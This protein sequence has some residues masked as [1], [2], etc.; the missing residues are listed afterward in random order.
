[1][2]SS[3]RNKTTTNGNDVYS[4]SDAWIDG[5][6]GNDWL[7]GAATAQT[8]IGGLGNDTLRGMG[9]DDILWGN[10]TNRAAPASSKGND[11]F[12]FEATRQANGFDTL[13]DY[14]WSDNKKSERD[15]L[16]LSLALK[17]FKPQND[18][19]QYVWLVA[20]DK[21]AVLW[22]DQD[23]Q[24]SGGA[25]SWARLE[26]VIAG[27][28]V[29]IQIKSD[30]SEGDYTLDVH[31]GGPV[32]PPPDSTAPSFTSATESLN[33]Q[34]N[35]SAGAT[36]ATIT[37]ASDN[38]GVT[39]YMFVHS[40]TTHSATSEDGYFSIN[41]SGQVQ[42]TAAGA[43]AHV[44][45]FE[46][47]ASNA[48]DYNI[49]AGDLA[50]NWSTAV[51]VTLNET[52]DTSDDASALSLWVAQSGDNIW[53]A[54]GTAIITATDYIMINKF[55]DG[56]AYHFFVNGTELGTPTE[57]QFGQ[58]ST[59]AVWDDDTQFRAGDV[60]KVVATFN[61]IDYSSE[62]IA[63]GDNVGAPLP[64][65]TAPSFTSATESLDYQENQSAGATVATITAASD[66]L[67]V[68]Q[69]M[70]VHSNTTHSATSEDGYFSINASGQVQI[71]AAGAAAHVNNFEAGASN[72][73]DYNIVAGDLAGNWSTAVAVTLNET[74]DTSD[75]A[76]ALSLWVAQSGDNIWNA[77]GTA[78]ITATDYIMINK[79]PD[80]TAY[81]F[82]VNG[83]E[84]GT[85]TELQFGQSS[86]VAVWD[87]DTQ[88]GAGDLV[89]VVATLNGIDYTSSII[90][91]GD[92]V[93]THSV[94]PA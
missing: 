73:H 74:N 1:M 45:N 69:Y 50:G 63:S 39:Q 79:F 84:L 3:N 2:P 22:I 88:F 94:I 34:E 36:V 93:G 18:I 68:T 62:V 38:L 5:L 13:M 14:H 91:S 53:N 71:T 31:P 26:G 20:S 83:T 6:A 87:D 15:V 54:A 52:N 23:G 67:G 30:H 37:A 43:A 60:V 16:D 9:G 35:Q 51:A 19:H 24:G 40:N 48:H 86:T 78:I 44:N 72:A 76:S 70:F 4:S 75:D 47:G 21:G 82:F 11:V 81:H 57:L 56:T 42:I 59:V 80:G 61:G 28:K 46:A 29:R 41:A 58:S 27:D 17:N 32:A 10:T 85:P 25:Q 8:L 55:P 90:A 7:A 89:T 49:V 33:Y 12:V 92:T 66:N 65:S 64:D 77:A